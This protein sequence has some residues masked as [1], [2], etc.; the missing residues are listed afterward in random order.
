MAIYKV[1]P[2]ARRDLVDIYVRG[3]REW[4]ESKAEAYI[5]QENS[6]VVAIGIVLKIID[7]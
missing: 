5:A 2:A 3:F 7:T 6:I 4:G 1:S